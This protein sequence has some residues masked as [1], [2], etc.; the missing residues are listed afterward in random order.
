MLAST[1]VALFPPWWEAPRLWPG[2]SRG[3]T[4][5]A[6]R[7]S[8]AYGR[9][10]RPSR[11]TNQAIFTR[12]PST[13]ACG[14]PASRLGACRP[15]PLPRTTE[16]YSSTAE[17]APSVIGYGLA[18][19]RDAETGGAVWLTYSPAAIIHSIRSENPWRAERF[20]LFRRPSPQASGLPRRGPHGGLRQQ[21]ARVDQ[22]RRLDTQPVE[23]ASQGILPLAIV[24]PVR[25]TSRTPAPGLH[26]PLNPFVVPFHSRTPDS[27]GPLGFSARLKVQKSS[28]SII[29][30]PGLDRDLRLQCLNYFVISR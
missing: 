10:S 28:Q 12:S 16:S 3:A 9:A 4:P 11:Y 21:P 22:I 5:S 26:R 7:S 15:P 23:A 1:C 13:A 14:T 19:N 27:N 30:S 18:P 29:K 24:W 25:S 8:D 17:M 2:A 20:R 6:H